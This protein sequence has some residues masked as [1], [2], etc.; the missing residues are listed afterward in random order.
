MRRILKNDMIMRVLGDLL[1]FC[2]VRN[3]NLHCQRAKVKRKEQ[4]RN[5]NRFFA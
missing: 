5:K 4:S 3:I 1:K 2:K